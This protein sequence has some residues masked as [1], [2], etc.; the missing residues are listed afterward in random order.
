MVSGE[1]SRLKAFLQLNGVGAHTKPV[2]TSPEPHLGPMRDTWLPLAYTDPALLYEILSHIAL[3]F[4]FYTK[5]NTDFKS[6]A[7][8]SLALRSVNERL[9]DPIEGI[10]DGVIGTILA[11][12]AFSVSDQES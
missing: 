11:F 8:H 1:M 4:N 2:Y 7:L 5:S 9:L 10:S 6:L 3:Q 12:A